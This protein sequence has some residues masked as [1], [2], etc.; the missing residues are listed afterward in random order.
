MLLAPADVSSVV[1]PTD[2]RGGLHPLKEVYTRG[3][4]LGLHRDYTPVWA[5]YTGITIALSDKLQC[6]LGVKII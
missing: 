4:T 5:A 1:A 6:K 2:A 3:S